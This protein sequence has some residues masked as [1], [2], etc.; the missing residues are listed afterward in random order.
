MMTK[1]IVVRTLEWYNEEVKSFQIVL[2]SFVES[3]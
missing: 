1:C 3:L 2:K